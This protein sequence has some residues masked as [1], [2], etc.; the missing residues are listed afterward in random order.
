MKVLVHLG[1][2]KTAT[3]YIQSRLQNS[4]NLLEKSG[5]IY[6]PLAEVRE[7][8]TER[9]K[10]GR[11]PSTAFL[12]RHTTSN[13]RLL[14]SDENILGS[15]LPPTSLKLYNNPGERVALLVDWLKG[16]E[17]ELCLTVRK[18]SSYLISRYIEYLRHGDYIDFKEYYRKINFNQFSWNYLINDI[19]NETGLSV[20]VQ[21]FE[22]IFAA[23]NEENYLASLTGLPKLKLKEANKG[24]DI[25]RSAISQQAFDI[26][27]L[28]AMNYPSSK[29]KDLVRL[30]DNAEQT[31]TSKPLQLFEDDLGGGVDFQYGLDSECSKDV[32][33]L[34]GKG[35]GI[36]NFLF[37]YIQ[38]MK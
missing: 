1:V 8:I 36:S 19:K 30:L 3:T 12:N 11:K 28:F 13:K 33:D 35:F 9:L 16:N 38:W 22:E 15:L 31:S 4:I 23:N 6:V 10:Q 21:K 32:K 7:N 17:I 14:I 20:T 2:H 24:N 18:P 5:V 34:R 37:R 26:V 29:V 25:R 27:K